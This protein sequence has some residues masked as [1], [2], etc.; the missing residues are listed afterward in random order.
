MAAKDTHSNFSD[1]RTHC[2]VR[3]PKQGWSGCAW[4][5]VGIAVVE[6]CCGQALM[7]HHAESV[8][9]REAPNKKEAA[10]PGTPRGTGW[11]ASSGAVGRQLS[12]RL[13]CHSPQDQDA[14][15]AP[16]YHQPDMACQARRGLGKLETS[17]SCGEMRSERVYAPEC[18]GAL[19]ILMR[20]RGARFQGWC[21]L[22]PACVLWL[23]PIVM[24]PGVWKPCHEAS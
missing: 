6:R 4:P 9:R 21:D 18:N 5:T 22:C 20:E 3:N 16:G 23:L 24:G 15:H 19:R 1:C 12:R 8:I 11:T 17:K 14:S 13:S 7:G 10:Q 2:A